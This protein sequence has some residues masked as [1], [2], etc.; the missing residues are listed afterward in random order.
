ME[1]GGSEESRL[2]WKWEGRPA[3]IPVEE[4]RCPSKVPAVTGQ[5]RPSFPTLIRVLGLPNYP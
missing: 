3:F 5:P 1:T 2:A 4:G